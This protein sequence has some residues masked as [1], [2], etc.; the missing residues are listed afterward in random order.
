[1]KSEG[2]GIYAC[3]PYDVNMVQDPATGN[4]YKV[5]ANTLGLPA[6]KGYPVTFTKIV[7]DGTRFTASASATCPPLWGPTSF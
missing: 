1:M 2:D 4:L 7:F 6:P 3:N 5:G